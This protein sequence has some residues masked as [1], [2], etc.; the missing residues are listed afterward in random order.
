MEGMTWLRSMASIVHERL[1]LS[2]HAHDIQN[3]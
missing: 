3:M 2:V 1:V